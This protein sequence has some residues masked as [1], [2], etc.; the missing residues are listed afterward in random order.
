[1]SNQPKFS[2]ALGPIKLAATSSEPHLLP[3]ISTSSTALPELVGQDLDEL[4]QIFIQLGEKSFRATQLYQAIY[5]QRELQS[6]HWLGFSQKL[7]QQIAR[8][9]VPLH[10]TLAQRFE[11]QDGTR[12]Y[13]FRLI[14][15]REI[16]SV[17]IPEPDRATICISSQVGCALACEFCLTAQLGLK[18]NLKTS[19]I[20]GQVIQVLN[21]I[22]GPH[23]SPDKQ[24][25]IVLMGMGEPLLNYAAVMA[26]IRL[27]ADPA[28]MAINPR[29]ITLSTAGI[30]PKIYQLGQEAIRPKLAISLTGTT[31]QIRNRLMPINQRYPLAELLQ[32]CRDFPV[33]P[34][35]RITIEYVMLNELT[36]SDQDAQR[37]ARLLRNLPVKINLIPHNPAPEL[38]VVASPW[39]RILRFQQL[40]IDRHYAVFIRRPR[41][42][43]IF[44]AC[45]QLAIK[46]PTIRP[47]G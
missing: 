15:G 3:I 28:G 24:I 26:A 1:M 31:D 36:D 41:G 11:A 17:W 20:V 6:A 22:Y 27:L 30:V 47:W 37:L 5:R 13:L 44:A 35:E 12:R 46:Q 21:D 39:E 7:R 42:Q 16:E 4:R 34:R 29:H 19:E 38:T 8:L 45:G 10:Q 14:D 18:R 25:N 9:A 2:D 32:A 33:K 23:H 43:D 40:L